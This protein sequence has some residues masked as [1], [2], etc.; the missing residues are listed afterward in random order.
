MAPR[1]RSITPLLKPGRPSGGG[2]PTLVWGFSLRYCQK[3]CLKEVSTTMSASVR[4]GFY[5]HHANFFLRQKWMYDTEHKKRLSDPAFRY[6]QAAWKQ[7]NLLKANK[8]FWSTEI[9]F[10]C[11]GKGH[12]S[13]YHPSTQIGTCKPTVKCLTPVC[14]SGLLEISES[15]SQ[16]C[17]SP[18]L[19]NKRHSDRKR[20]GPGPSG[21]AGVPEADAN[22]AQCSCQHTNSE[23]AKGHAGL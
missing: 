2:S 22:A 1:S 17:F 18:H 11:S 3:V 13:I 4:S 9:H 21:H 6:K 16:F 15:D 8:I 12:E 5:L 14:V 19:L 23:V 20:A 10:G 7:A